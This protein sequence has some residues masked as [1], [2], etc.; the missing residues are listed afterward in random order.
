MAADRRR[1]S[2]GFTVA[3][4]D[5]VRFG[6]HSRKSPNTGHIVRINGGYIY[7]M[8]TDGKRFYDIECLENEIME[9]L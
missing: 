2:A 4:G 6:G 7:V 3:I 9:V 1:V 5:R 8:V